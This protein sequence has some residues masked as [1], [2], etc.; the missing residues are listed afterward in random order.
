[1][2]GFKV[3]KSGG[4]AFAL[5]AL[6][7]CS[8]GSG[9]GPGT[10]TLTVALTDA[11]VD[12]VA[13]IWIEFDGVTLRR[14]GGPPIEILFEEAVSIDLLTLTDGNS[15][16]LLDGEELPAGT[17]QQLALHVNAQHDG[18]Y[19]SYVVTYDEQQIEL[20]IPSGAQ[21]G[22]K[23]IDGFTITANQETSFLI[24]WDA[25]M[26]LV[27][28]PGLPGYILRPTLRIIDMTEYGILTGTVAMPLVTH[29]AC[30]NDLNLDT[31][32]A[33]YI[34]DQ[35]DTSTDEPDD[36]GGAGHTPVATAAVTQEPTGEYTYEVILSPGEYTVA[37]TCQAGADDPEED[38]DIEFVAPTQVSVLDGEVSEVHFE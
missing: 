20:F 3:V 28:P 18:V 9:S 24:D 17:Y 12:G 32:N 36:I 23:L 1:M 37:F 33:V 21:T 13:E 31:G 15:V 22:L 11:P 34:Y 25:R 10:G 38:D 26:G 30:L 4:A 5:V 16:L 6:A 27:N 2:E 35:F 14:S 19:D 8:S 29:A 7:A